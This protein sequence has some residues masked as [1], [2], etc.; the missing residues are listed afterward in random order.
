MFMRTRINLW[1]WTASQGATPIVPSFAIRAI[2]AVPARPQATQGGVG[3]I[4]LGTR[5]RVAVGN[6]AIRWIFTANPMDVEDI[7]PAHPPKS[8]LA[9]H[10]IQQS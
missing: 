3:W 4:V 6:L 5:D 2:S 1:K 10:L 7:F 8:L 9:I